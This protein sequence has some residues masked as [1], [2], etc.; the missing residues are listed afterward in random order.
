MQCTTVRCFCLIAV[1]LCCFS[2]TLSCDDGFRYAKLI[3][4]VSFDDVTITNNVIYSLS[5]VRTK[6]TCALEC[7]QNRYCVSFSYNGDRTCRLLSVKFANS[8]NHVPSL[9]WRY[10]YPDPGYCPVVDG[11][12]LIDRLN[13][14]FK[15]STNK[16]SF[17]KARDICSQSCARL[18]VLDTEEKNTAVNSYINATTGRGHYYIGLTDMVTEGV[19]VWQDGHTVGFTKWGGKEPNDAVDGE[20]CVVLKPWTARWNDVSCMMQYRYICEKHPW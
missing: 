7:Q 13:I 19:F 12:V 1:V 17:D 8:A 2:A 14:C 18:I 16:Q 6:L 4:N 10:Y 20:D 9:G 5:D 15:A 3:R 11:Y